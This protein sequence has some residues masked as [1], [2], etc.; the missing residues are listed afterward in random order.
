[1]VSEKLQKLKVPPIIHTS[2]PSSNAASSDVPMVSLTNGVLSNDHV[3]TDDKPHDRG[4]G[5]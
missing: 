3:P 2:S 1:M 5:A 4:T